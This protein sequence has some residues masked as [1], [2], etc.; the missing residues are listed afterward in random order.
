MINLNMCWTF[1]SRRA[2]V[3]CIM[4][5]L[6]VFVCVPERE[7]KRVKKNAFVCVCVCVCVCLC[8]YVC[9]CVKE[10]EHFPPNEFTFKKFTTFS[11]HFR[12]NFSECNFIESWLFFT[13][14]YYI[15]GKWVVMYIC[16]RVFFTGSR[17]FLNFN[18][19]LLLNCK[20]IRIT[21]SSICFVWFEI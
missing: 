10:I 11:K 14:F 1:E 16:W 4:P 21:D 9:L 15:Q 19:S 18:I 6:R 7:S 17:I 3:L 20:W 2:E 5:N 12:T 13:Q 8:E